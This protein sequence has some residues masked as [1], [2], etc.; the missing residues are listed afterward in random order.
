M[1]TLANLCLFCVAR[2]LE[3]LSRVGKHLTRIDKEILL[4]WLCDHDGFTAERLPSITY[5]LISPQLQQITFRYNEQINDGLL[6]KLAVTGC[7]LKSIT[8]IR[9][10]NVTGM[11]LLR[12]LHN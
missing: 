9:C 5:N 7:R 12:T 4:E 2:N 3:Q 6:N 8:I 11:V 10:P 1:K